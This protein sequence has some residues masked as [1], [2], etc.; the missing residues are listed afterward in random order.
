MR[1]ISILCALGLVGLGTALAVKG[2][3][4]SAAAPG[5]AVRVGVFDSR[6]VAVAFFHS[7]YNT[8]INGMME[9]Y[10]KAQ[11]AKDQKRVEELKTK[12]KKLQDKAHLQGFGKV[13]VDDL[14][15]PVKAKLADVA[16]SAGVTAIADDYS[17]TAP[18]TETVDVTEAV[19][20][21]YEPNEKTLKMIESMKG[22]KPVPLDQFPIED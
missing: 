10:K 9:E 22:V 21:L 15:V 11:A 6:A 13:P 19:A 1:A 20:K 7:R 16:K 14:L 18:G 12:G 8:E 5:S 3:D 17:Y 4:A 2:G